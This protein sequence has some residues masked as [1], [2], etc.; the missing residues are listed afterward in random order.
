M[1]LEL[2]S[3]AT[4]L[5]RKYSREFLSKALELAQAYGWKPLG[6]RLPLVPGLGNL[7]AL[8]NGI[9]LTNDGQIVLAEDA[10]GLAEALNRALVDIPDQGD[11]FDW[12]PKLW[13]EDD[14]PPW[15]SPAE[16]AQLEEGL[17]EHIPDGFG[18]HPFEF[19]AGA[20]KRHLIDLIRFCRLGSFRI[21]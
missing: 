10:L 2:I 12:N 19:F 16:R 6:T 1:T 15:L 9:Y 5:C 13:R 20:E 21:V 14:L 17:M 18:M 3:E 4:A 8:W 11:A 7:N